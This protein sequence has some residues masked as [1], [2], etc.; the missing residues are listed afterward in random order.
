MK[1]ILASAD[2]KWGLMWPKHTLAVWVPYIPASIYQRSRLAA[3]GGA[4]PAGI[5]AVAGETVDLSI[6]HSRPS[7]SPC[8]PLPSLLL[9]L[10]KR[11]LVKGLFV[12]HGYLVPK[13]FVLSVQFPFLTLQTR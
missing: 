1:W 7:L 4:Q 12:A 6:L 10:M 3:Q 2:E 9:Q 5:F 8:C 11:R 13:T